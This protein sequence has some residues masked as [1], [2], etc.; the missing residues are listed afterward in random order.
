[1]RGRDVPEARGQAEIRYA[2]LVLVLEMCVAVKSL[3]ILDIGI[4][5]HVP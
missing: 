2:V 4:V 5:C 1:V 3:M